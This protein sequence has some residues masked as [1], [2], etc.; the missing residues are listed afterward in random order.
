M[1]AVVPDA[2]VTLAGRLA[3]ASGAV[4]RRYFR[5][6]LAIE[7]KSDASPVTV[8]DREA[9]AAIRDILTAECPDHGIFGEE[10][11]QH[12]L[13]AEYL[14]VIDPIDGTQTFISG[15]PLFGTL[16]A[17]LHRGRPVLGV[18]DQP[19]LGERWLGIAGQRTTFNGAPIST[20]PCASLD[21]ATL[22]ST[23]P[24]LFGATEATAFDRLS[25]SVKR[26]RYGYDCYGYGVLSLGF[27]DIVVEANLKPYDFCALI[28]VVEG[29]G[30]VISDWSGTALDLHS[31]GRMCVV[32]DV[33]IHDAVL[34]ELRG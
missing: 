3:D 18:I 4:I 23:S 29:A 20:R 16:I 33:R 1:A 6:G 25:R 13:D 17:L 14:W 10:H 31:D 5:T 8:A 32:G 21:A 11:G 24:Q 26:T 28:N 9:E 19:I 2:Y 12:G 7:E 15:V 22:T 30:G 27:V 34:A